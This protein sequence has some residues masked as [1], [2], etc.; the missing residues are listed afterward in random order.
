M[1]TAHAVAQKD[2]KAETNLQAENIKS[3]GNLARIDYKAMVK[4]TN[5]E[6]KDWFISAFKNI[7][8]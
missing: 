5:L 6:T 7:K 8:F 4:I 1:D 2:N 3:R